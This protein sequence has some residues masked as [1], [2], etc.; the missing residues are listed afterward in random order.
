MN[1][2]TTV[3]RN[4]DGLDEVDSSIVYVFSCMSNKV[5]GAFHISFL[6]EYTNTCE[7]IGAM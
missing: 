6:G 4:L 1:Y 3:L 2:I 7:L 5:Y